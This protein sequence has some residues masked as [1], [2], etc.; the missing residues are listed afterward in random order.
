MARLENLGRQATV[1]GYTPDLSVTM[2]DRWPL[3]PAGSAWPASSTNPASPFAR[4]V[5]SLR[6][7]RS[8]RPRAEIETDIKTIEK[9][10][11]R[12]LAEVRG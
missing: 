6:V 1:R 12:M 9:D 2:A 8:P 5:S 3:M 11:A 10:I 7:D 4:R